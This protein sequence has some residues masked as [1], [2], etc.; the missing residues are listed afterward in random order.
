MASLATLRRALL[1]SL[2][3]A[4]LPCMCARPYYQCTVLSGRYQYTFSVAPCCLQTYT[5]QGSEYLVSTP[6]LHHTRTQPVRIVPYPHS[7]D[8]LLA[9]PIARLAGGYI[10]QLTTS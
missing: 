2:T 5:L 3:Y 8:R 10:G 7:A 9:V 1:E 4:D 6:R